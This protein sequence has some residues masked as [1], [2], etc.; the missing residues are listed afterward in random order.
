MG[1]KRN[2]LLSVI[3]FLAMG[4]IGF[5]VMGNW[6][7][8]AGTLNQAMRN[9]KP[10]NPNAVVVAQNDTKTSGEEKTTRSSDRN[11]PASKNQTKEKS[12][13][14]TQKQPKEFRPTETIEADQAVDFPYDI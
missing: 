2:K 4:L 3:G 1:S 12:T 9:P 11:A 5:V 8:H 6:V 10:E 14:T 13:T 7:A